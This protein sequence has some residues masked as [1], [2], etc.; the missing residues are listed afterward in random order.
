ML[1]HSILKREVITLGHKIGDYLKEI[2]ERRGLTMRQ[3][4]IKTNV[5]QPYL[6]QIENGIKKPSPEILKRLAP[7]YKVSYND[8]MVV[9]GY[10]PD[11]DEPKPDKAKL[12]RIIDDLEKTLKTAKDEL[13]KL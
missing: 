2:R 9:A 1:Q 7:A 10:L 3:V 13:S 8:L 5:S 11:V 4:A 6:S 12:K